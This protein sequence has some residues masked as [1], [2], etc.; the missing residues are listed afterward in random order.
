MKQTPEYI[1]GQEAEA[2]FLD[3]LKTVLTVPKS[4]VPNPFSKPR[5][6]KKPTAV[7]ANRLSVC[8]YSGASD[9]RWERL[10]ILAGEMLIGEPLAGDL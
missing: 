2:R 1:E 10:P 8:L 7:R 9:D 5:K 6:R 4:S 3:A